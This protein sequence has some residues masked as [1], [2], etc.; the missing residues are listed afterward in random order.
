[1]RRIKV[2]REKPQQWRGEQHD[3]KGRGHNRDAVVENE[4]IDGRE[5]GES[6]GTRLIRG[7]EHR[8][9]GRKQGNARY[10]RDD[11]ARAGDFAELRETGR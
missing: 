4:M 7:V 11:H 1:M 10:K 2:S 5:R 3:R 8:Q 6:H 9:K